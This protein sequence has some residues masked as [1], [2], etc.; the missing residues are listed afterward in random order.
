MPKTKTKQPTKS[1][2]YESIN[3][4]IQLFLEDHK[5]TKKAQDH[6]KQIIDDHL[7]PK[8][9]GG[10]SQNPPKLDDDGN[11]IEAYCRYHER[12]EPVENMVISGG[13]SKGYCRAAIS[14]WTKATKE[15]KA[16]E[17]AS[18]DAVLEGDID[19]AKE[20]AQEAKDLQS[21]IT[22]PSFYDYDKDW[23]AFNA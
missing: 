16:L 2:V 7:K 23:E 21:A 12:Y 3:A 13:K 18:T 9:G 19:L 15:V 20:K 10:H 4:S 5:L 8:A 17:K 11:I 6:L 22:S 1:E 14:K